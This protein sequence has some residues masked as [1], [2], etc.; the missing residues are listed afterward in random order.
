MDITCAAIGWKSMFYQSIKIELTY[1]WYPFQCTEWKATSVTVVLSSRAIFM[2][3]WIKLSFIQNKCLEKFVFYLQCVKICVFLW[4]SIWPDFTDHSYKNQPFLQ[5]FW[6]AYCSMLYESIEHQPLKKWEVG[7][8]TR[9]C[10]VFLLSLLLCSS[11]F[12]WA[13]QRWN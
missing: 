12:L 1:S 3:L 7:R 11:P 4:A 10:P 2:F 5:G 8:N 6:L 13:L 9:L